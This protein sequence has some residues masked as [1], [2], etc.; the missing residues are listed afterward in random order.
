M[1]RFVNRTGVQYGRLTALQFLKSTGKGKPKWVCQCACGKIVEITSSNLA[2]GHTTSCGCLHR[3]VLQARR[4]YP[5]D[6][7]N[8]YV[9]W[10]GIK[11]RCKASKGKNFTWYEKISMCPT[12]NNS[13]MQFY[14]D[15]GKRPSPNHSI[16][17]K[18]NKG[19]YCKEN[20][21]WATA[22][23]QANNRKT[24]RQLEF[25]GQTHTLAEWQEITGINQSTIAARIDRYGWPTNVALTRAVGAK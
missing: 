9:I 23:I 24:N 2:T 5:K 17:R 14:V 16:E 15:M 1:P 11:T 21:I 8:E 6:L 25:N 3:E 18:D 10:R 20:C 22:K 13:F 12:W 19:N 4:K 7:H